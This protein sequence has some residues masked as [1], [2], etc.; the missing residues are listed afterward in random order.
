M[1]ITSPYS[2]QQPQLRLVPQPCPGAPAGAVLGVCLLQR[3]HQC[4]QG[5]ARPWVS[6]T[7]SLTAW[8]GLGSA[9]SLQTCTAGPGLCGASVTI[10]SLTLTLTCRPTSQA[11]L[12]PTSSPRAAQQAPHG[13]S[14]TVGL[15]MASHRWAVVG[16]TQGLHQVLP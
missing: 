13:C 1:T 16:I 6:L 2:S 7:R 8:P 12:T 15:T 4:A 14:G 10:T 11:E 9:W 3:S 5:R